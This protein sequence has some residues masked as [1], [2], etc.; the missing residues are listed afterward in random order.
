[1]DRIEVPEELS[2]LTI[3]E[4]T[5]LQTSIKDA[6]QELAGDAAKEDDALKEVERLGAEYDRIGEELASRKAAEAERAARAEEALN[7]FADPEP[8]STET[9]VEPEIEAAVEAPVVEETDIEGEG[10]EEVAAATETEVTAEA[11]AEEITEETTVEEATEELS[12]DSAEAVADPLA[13]E[14]AVAA[15]ASDESKASIEEEPEAL[16]TEDAEVTAEATDEPP[17]EEATMTTESIPDAAAETVA[18]LEGEAP[19]AV[20]PAETSSFAGFSIMR[21]TNSA[22]GLNEGDELSVKSLAESITRKSHGMQNIPTGTYERI[23]V[24]TM[25]ADYGERR[26]GSGAEENF[27]ILESL[28][29]DAE[30]L[31]AAGGNCAPLAPS[32]DFFRLAE[33]LNPVEQCLP[34]VE[35]PRGGIRYITPPDFRDAEGGVRVTTEAEDA[36]G[37]PPTAPKPC[38]AVA[39]PPIEECRVDAVSKCVTFGNLNFRVFPEQVEAFLEDLDVIFT[40]EKEIFYLDAIDAASTAVTSGPRYGAVRSILWD[41]AE[42]AAGYRRRNHMAPDATLNVMLPSWVAELVKVDMVNDFSLGLSFVGADTNALA[43]EMLARLN[44]APCFY[45]DSATGA[46]QAFN[47]PQLAG[48]LNPFPS[49][50]V[51]YLFAPG[52]FVRLDAGTLD[53]GIV[54]DSVLNGTNDL[55]MFSEQWIQVC[56]V[57]LESVRLESTVCPD[58]TA[59]AAVAP[60]ICP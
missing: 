55:Q 11:A 58:G 38:V 43:A 25:H 33:A 50:V 40:E 10:T 30:A 13:A 42:A 6:A 9:E 32:Y 60:I 59:P 8:E 31:V 39:C 24:G 3:E 47:D 46:G 19:D 44:L 16:A 36:A 49:T 57:G 41:L 7:R 4:L 26:L 18:A 29:H 28:R 17:Q 20:S 37:Y 27:A 12:D 23:V 15:V 54:R 35:A 56:Q 45:Y 22:A 48:P 53:L 2:G 5:E 34:A 1:M 52:T 21:A 14:V 51:S